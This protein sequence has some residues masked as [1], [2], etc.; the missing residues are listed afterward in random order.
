MT[1]ID[2]AALPR[3]G[4]SVSS[5]GSAAE[6]APQVSVRPGTVH[7]VVVDVDGGM[8]VVEAG[9]RIL[10]LDGL[11]AAKPGMRLALALPA[12]FPGLGSSVAA[13]LP[14]SEAVLSA[15]LLAAPSVLRPVMLSPMSD[16]KA[17]QAFIV[18][19][20][21]G[22]GGGA[23]TDAPAG[24][25]AEVLPG[26]PVRSP[27]GRAAGF[28]LRTP[29]GDFLAPSGT[30]GLA[31]GHWLMLLIPESAAPA[32]TAA[33]AT[34]RHA[35]ADA[36]V[37]LAALVARASPPAAART[38][39]RHVGTAEAAGADG[40]A[41]V[42]RERPVGVPA[43]WEYLA[44]RLTFHGQGIEVLV[45]RVD[46]GQ[47]GEPAQRLRALLLAFGLTWIGDVQLHLLVDGD[48]VDLVVRTALPLDPAALAEIHAVLRD[49]AGSGRSRLRGRVVTGLLDLPER[50]GR[51]PMLTRMA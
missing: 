51:A 13:R 50:R 35:A 34:P 11:V 29:L 14:D 49:A 6:T 47:R 3:I 33:Q 19:A 16:G 36:A 10:G 44:E 48:S 12:G 42:D 28:V 22:A 9:G 43:C 21:A 39:A 26:E 32:G 15:R 38:E 1:S 41:P 40:A 45:E 20:G 31:A 5:R 8:V 17:C 30:P 25:P 18:G 4:L 23:G 2:T 46:P 24:W 27:D 7:A 37:A